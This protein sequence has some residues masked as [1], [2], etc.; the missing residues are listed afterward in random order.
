MAI[1]VTNTTGS[2]G[3]SSISSTASVS[4]PSST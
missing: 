4:H 1:S 3:N 2:H